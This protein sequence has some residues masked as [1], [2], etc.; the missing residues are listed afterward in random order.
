MANASART[1]KP[2]PRGNGAGAPTSLFEQIY[3]EFDALDKM[4]DEASIEIKEQLG[5]KM[6]DMAENGMSLVGR[7]RFNLTHRN[8]IGSIVDTG[9]DLVSKYHAV[10]SEGPAIIRGVQKILGSLSS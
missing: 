8:S 6:L 3:H 7:T 2:S 1:S 5:G 9:L 10:K 4:D